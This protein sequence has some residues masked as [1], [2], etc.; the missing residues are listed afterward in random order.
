M[1]DADGVVNAEAFKVI[2]KDTVLDDNGLV[3]ITVK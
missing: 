3:V 1:A 2:N